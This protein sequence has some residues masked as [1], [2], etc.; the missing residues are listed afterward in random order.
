[1]RIFDE[2]DLPLL[3]QHIQNRPAEEQLLFELL[4]GSG[5]RF[6][7]AFNLCEKDVDLRQSQ[8]S[9][10]G[11]GMKRRLVPLTPGARKLL[12]KK[13]IS[14]DKSLWPESTKEAQLRRWVRNWGVATGFD[15]KYGGLYPHKLR[16]SIA[17]HL[18]RRGAQLP[19]IQKL[20][21]HSELSTTEKYTHLNIQDLVKVYDD[22][23]PDLVK[24]SIERKKK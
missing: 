18:V 17:T 22:C 12:H 11:K 2:D 23:F 7:E 15:E 1:M 16:H 20:L 6:S 19:Q 3:L 8:I 24:S 13:R 14:P 4:Y 9:V 21:G 5:L 10:L